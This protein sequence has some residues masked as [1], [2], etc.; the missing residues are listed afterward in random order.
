MS[1]VSIS[2]NRLDGDTDRPGDC[3]KSRSR[4]AALG[5]KLAWR[6]S[7]TREPGLMLVGVM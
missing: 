3:D 4:F 6:A 1:N 7:S 2:S 5:L